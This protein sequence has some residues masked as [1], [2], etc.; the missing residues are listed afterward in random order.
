MV[1]KRKNNFSKIVHKPATALTPTKAYKPY[2]DRRQKLIKHTIVNLLIISHV[3][4]C[5]NFSLATKIPFSGIKGK[6]RK[7]NDEAMMY[8]IL[9][10]FISSEVSFS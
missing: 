2:P 9:N 10:L 7:L 5:T 6:D 1:L 8:T 3:F 4:N